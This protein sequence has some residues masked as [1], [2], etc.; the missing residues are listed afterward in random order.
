MKAVRATVAACL[1]ACTG[2]ALP[3]YESPGFRGQIL[4]RATNMPVANA[5]VSVTPFW[6]RGPTSVTISDPAGRF[7]IPPSSALMGQRIA[8]HPI[9]MAEAWTDARVI[10]MASGYAPQQQAALDLTKRETPT[11]LIYLDRS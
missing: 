7:A 3:G 1:L 10:V 9:S 4:D 11:L 6:G 8:L 5:Q 2:C